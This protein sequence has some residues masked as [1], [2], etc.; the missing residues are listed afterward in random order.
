MINILAAVL[1]GGSFAASNDVEIK[2]L[3]A[4]FYNLELA[5]FTKKLP[6]LERHERQAE[7]LAKKADCKL[8]TDIGWVHARVD[9]ALGSFSPGPGDQS[10]PGR[11]GVPAAGN[12][13]DSA[14]DQICRS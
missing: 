14:S 5:Q 2:E 8:T 1:L 6:V 4:D 9:F 3:S 11:D 10:C 13:C 7:R 12:I